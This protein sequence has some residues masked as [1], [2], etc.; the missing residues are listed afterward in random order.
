MSAHK[1]YTDK[2]KKQAL[3]LHKK[4]WGYARIA[5]VIGCYPSTV[6]RWVDDSPQ[7]SHPGPAYSEKVK[8]AAIDYYKDNKV[9]IRRAAKEHGVSPKTLSRWLDAECIVPRTHSRV[10]REG[11][12]A[13]LKAGMSKV[14]VARKHKCS[15]SW[16]YRVWNGD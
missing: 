12:I 6:K 16:V 11:I 7:K 13:D 5:K 10:G 4:G 8:K 9:S 2:D 1:T 3:K 14:N 15:E